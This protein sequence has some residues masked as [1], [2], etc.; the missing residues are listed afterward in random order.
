MA[1]IVQYAFLFMDK[2]EMFSNNAYFDDDKLFDW[3]IFKLKIQK[4]ISGFG[5]FSQCNESWIF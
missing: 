1:I 4:D 5:Y 2:Y 3:F